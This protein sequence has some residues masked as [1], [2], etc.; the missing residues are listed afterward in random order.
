MKD[1]R[2]KIAKMITPAWP[3]SGLS[4]ADQI[5]KLVLDEFELE[6]EAWMDVHEERQRTFKTNELLEH[7]RKVFLLK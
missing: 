4:R 6:L 2:E 5:I 1:L 7:F 3:S